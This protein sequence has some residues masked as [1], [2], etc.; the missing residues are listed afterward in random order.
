MSKKIIVSLFI[1]CLFLLSV[2]LVQAQS[3][4][5]DKITVPLTDPSRPVHLKAGLLNGSITVTASSG[6]DV[7]VEAKIRKDE[8]DDEEKDEDDDNS[9]KRAGL[10]RINNSST[11]LSVEEDNNDVDVSSGVLGGSRTVDL[12]IQVPVTTS[13]KLSTINN[14]DVHVTGVKGDVEVSNTNGS[15]SLSQI[16]GS[17]VADALNGEIVVTFVS[18]D[19][20]KT[21]SFSSLNG[22]I[23]VTLPPDTKATMSLKTEQGEIYSDFDLKMENSSSKIEDNKGGKRGKYRVRMEQMMKGTINGGGTEMQFK[24]FNG[25]IYIRKGK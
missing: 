14:G 24:N 10:K 4:N 8:D 9:R 13:M 16:S 15:I 12:F 18:I 17:A 6:K 11:G 25:S 22:D 20:K 1:I 5:A 3:S 21:M 19:P 2:T 23:D 7:T